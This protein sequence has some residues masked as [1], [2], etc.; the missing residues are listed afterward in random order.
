[1]G[2]TDRYDRRD[3]KLVQVKELRSLFPDLSIN[4][5]KVINVHFMKDLKISEDDFII[6]KK[7]GDMKKLAEFLVTGDKS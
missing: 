3:D 4:W 5:L 1:M 7:F 6:V 2:R